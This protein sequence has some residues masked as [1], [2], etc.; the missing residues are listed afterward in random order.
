MVLF[1][2]RAIAATTRPAGTVVL[3]AQTTPSLARWYANM[4][5]RGIPIVLMGRTAEVGSTVSE[6]LKPE[7]EGKL[8]A[9][10]LM[11]AFVHCDS[12]ALCSNP[13][14]QLSRNGLV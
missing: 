11:A 14:P 3:K 2:T 10:R 9:L 6:A 8:H 7:Y 13:L 5:T 4:T 1:A 12:D